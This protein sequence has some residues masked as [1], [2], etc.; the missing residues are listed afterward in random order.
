MTPTATATATASPAGI[1]VRSALARAYPRW[2]GVPRDRSWLFLETVLPLA[3]TVAMIYVYEGLH[4]PE[5]FLGFVVMGGAMLAYWA[6]VL[7]GMGT[8]L[9]WDRDSGNLELYA[10]APTS[11]AAVLS[12][13]ALGGLINST[14]RAVAVVVAA[15][16]LFHVH[17]LWS[18]VPAA[19]GVFLL[20]LVALYAM[21]ALMGSLFLFYGRE[22]WHVASGLQEPVYFLGGFYFPVHSLGAVLGGVASLLPI[23]LGLDAMRQLLLPGSASLVGTGWEAL[24]LAVQVAIY[25]VLAHRALLLMELRARRDGRLILRGG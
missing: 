3:G 17:F 14:V 11:F 21:G 7:W 6:N 4:A 8:Q 22:V 20:A 5:R 23:T 18:A 24:G 10:I 19:L 12:G 1:F 25:A 9:Y 16:L 13:M 15:S 2:R